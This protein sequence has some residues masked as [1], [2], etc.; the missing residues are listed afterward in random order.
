MLFT[1]EFQDVMAAFENIAKKHVSMGSQGL[2]RESKD[3]W[4][5]Q[6]YYCDGRVNDAFKLFLLG[7]SFGK[8][9]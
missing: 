3:I 1:K 5:K 6:H 2:T 9:I 7:Y 8:I 4:H